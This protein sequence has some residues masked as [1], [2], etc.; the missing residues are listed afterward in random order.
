MSE[1]SIKYAFPYDLR[2]PIRRLDLL[3]ALASNKTKTG[4]LINSA[5]IEIA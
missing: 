5:K 1:Q 2:S 3:P 4:V